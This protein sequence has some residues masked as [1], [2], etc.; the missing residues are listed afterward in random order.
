[1]RRSLLPLLA[2]VA[3]LAGCGSEGDSRPVEPAVAAA[4]GSWRVGW[5]E[6]YGE[7]DA[8]LR[9]RV[10]SFRV[11]QDGWAAEVAVSNETQLTWEIEPEFGLM[12]FANADL[13]QLERDSQ[14]GRLPP[15]RRARRLVPEPPQRL[16][17]GERWE[18]TIS[19]PGSLVAGSWVRIVFGVFTTEDDPPGEMQQVV[20]WISD[21]A[22]RLPPRP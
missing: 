16:G 18:A 19:A 5:N 22:Q 4:P 10:E 15:P 13:E 7:G 11:T 20:S 3:L 21:G 2:A 9:F 14:A 17:P 1:M 12:L 6:T 8:V